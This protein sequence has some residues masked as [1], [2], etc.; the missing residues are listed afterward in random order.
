M[1]QTRVCDIVA[2]QYIF[3]PPQ[4]GGMEIIM[5]RSL[6]CGR[7]SHIPYAD[8]MDLINLSFGFTTP[9]T[10][11]LGLL[12]KLYKEEY[13]PQ[14]QNY[15]VT[16]DGVLTTAVGAY[17]HEISVCGHRLACRGIGNV[18]VHPDHRSKGYMKDAMNA[19]LQDM[20]K[21][22]IV[23]STLGGRRQRYLYFGYDKAGS[24]YNFH[25]SRDNI[26]HVYGDL[27]APFTVREVTTPADPVI[28]SMVAL[29]EASPVNPL[30]PRDRYLDIANSWKAK[31]LAILDGARFVGYCVLVGGKSVSEIQTVSDGEF[32]SA[33]RSLYAFI[34]EGF[35]VNLPAHQFS[36]RRDITP[37]AEG[38]SLGHA[39]HFNI[40]NYRA[41]V[42]AFLD[43]KLQYESLPDGSVVL[44]IHGYAG[45]ERIRVSVK[46]GEGG[47]ESVDTAE[48]ADYELTHPEAISFL[49][50]PISPLREAANDLCKLWFPLP[51][52]M[53]HAD[54]V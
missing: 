44:L 6:Y 19:A 29:N 7:G 13:R 53:A 4:G 33:I 45:D 16:E 22:G 9:E 10:Q 51:I 8:Y 48:P 11:F 23:L 17:D 38:M 30:R 24:L 43:L 41:A 32:M 42:E 34:G 54:E 18:A 2:F 36:Y 47:V 27:T 14:D 5:T 3:M 40:L 35:G 25:V 12:P 46:N 15:V 52:C 21:D 31:L 49:F 50:S 1:S 39:M 28:D 37:I 26:R 20:I